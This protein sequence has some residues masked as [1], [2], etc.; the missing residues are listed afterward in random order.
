[1]LVSLPV[2]ILGSVTVAG[3]VPVLLFQPRSTTDEYLGCKTKIF[4]PILF[5]LFLRWSLALSPKLEYS[6]AIIA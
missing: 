3:N 5:F 1:M 4:T 6:G 2:F